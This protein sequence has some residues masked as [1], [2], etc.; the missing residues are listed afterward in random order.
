MKTATIVSEPQGQTV[1]LPNDVRLEAEEVYVKQIGPS[2][3]LIPKHYN[4]WQS[5]VESLDQ[6]TDDYMQE[7]MQPAQ[8]SRPGMF[9]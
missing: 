9:E 3:V 7:R 6:F 4:A 8:Q 5:L 2:I 1:H